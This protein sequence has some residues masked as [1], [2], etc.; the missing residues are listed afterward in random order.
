M[1]HDQRPDLLADMLPYLQVHLEDA[2]YT[3]CT[4][5]WREMDYVPAYNKFYLICEGEGWLRIDGKEYRPVPGQLC[6]MPAHALQSYSAVSDRPYKKYWCHFT[7]T[8]GGL[9]MFQWLEAPHL[10]D[11][12]PARM[13]D[14]LRL[15]E[16]L[17]AL[18]QDAG[19]LSRI[20]EKAVLLE[21]VA[22]FLAES[23]LRLRIMPNRREEVERL[24]RI[25]AFVDAHLSEA[26]TLERMAKQVHLHPNYLVRY[27]NKHFAMSPLKYLNRKR[28]QK[29]RSLLAST[30]LSVKE[31]AERVGYPDTNHFAKAF[32]KETSCS[33]TEYRLRFTGKGP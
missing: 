15:F 32:R 1:P 22:I 19:Y 28:M 29:A 10:L 14:L 3:E 16:D 8:M 11:V 17:A 25:D 12:P 26:L 31:V 13:G 21:I 9:D 33:P 23:N 18:H 27:F 7:A 6:H 2:H 4:T 30:S 5:Q 20:R 24:Q